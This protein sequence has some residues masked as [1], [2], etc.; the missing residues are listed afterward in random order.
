M[1]WSTT[2]HDVYET[3]DTP[4]NMRCITSFEAFHFSPMAFTATLSRN[5]G[6]ERL[7]W[8]GGFVHKNRLKASE[9][10][11]DMIGK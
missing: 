2:S 7:A 5:R 8:Q 10:Q 11:N 3:H 6:G 1:S 4:S 9:G